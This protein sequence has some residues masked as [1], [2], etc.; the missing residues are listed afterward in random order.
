MEETNPIKL[1]EPILPTT[2]TTE[3]LVRPKVDITRPFEKKEG[4][5]NEGSTTQV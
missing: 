2:N 3:S 1:V 5:F 4:R